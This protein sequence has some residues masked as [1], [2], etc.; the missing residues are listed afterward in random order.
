MW[1]D[2]VVHMYAT[3][4]SPQSCVLVRGSNKKWLGWLMAQ[5]EGHQSDFVSSQFSHN[6][7]GTVFPAFSEKNNK[8]SLLCRQWLRV[9]LQLRSTG[10]ERTSII[11]TML[12]VFDDW[13]PD[14]SWFV[15]SSSVPRV[16]VA[17]GFSPVS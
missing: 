17:F 6:Y 12:F 15:R 16:V 11:H 5:M 1:D 7:D 13:M 9:G 8:S 3:H 2:D 10:R 14:A 4:K